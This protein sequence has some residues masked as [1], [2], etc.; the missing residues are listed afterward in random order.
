MKTVSLLRL[1]HHE[2]KSQNLGKFLG[3]KY[4]W[5][6]YNAVSL[7]RLNH[8]EQ[9]SQNLGKFLGKKYVWHWYNAV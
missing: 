9:K 5:H 7:L 8:H 3:K 6:W 2:Q 1:N 4:V